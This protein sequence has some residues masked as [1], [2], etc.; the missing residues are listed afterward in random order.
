MKHGGRG[1]P[2]I[3][4][5]SRHAHTTH[6]EEVEEIHHAFLTEFDENDLWDP[7]RYGEALALLKTSFPSQTENSAPKVG[8]DGLIQRS[9]KPP[10][11]TASPSRVNRIKKY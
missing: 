8:S 5:P 9:T 11:R 4:Q 1:E 3:I 2:R 10:P 7:I 6:F